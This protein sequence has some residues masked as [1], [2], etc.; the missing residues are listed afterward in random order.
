[1]RNQKTNRQKGFTVIELMVV[2]VIM[3][4]LTSAGIV[5]WNQQ[6]PRRTLAIA[7][8]ETITNLRKVQAY[9][10]SSRNL[11]T[12]E[13]PKYYLT[14]FEGGASSYTV[15]AIA[16]TSFSYYDVE[17]INLPSGVT[18]GDITLRD[19]SGVETD[20]KC[21]FVISGV[22]FGKTY[23]Y[24]S[25]ICDSSISAVA[26]NF[27]ELAPWAN[28]SMDL[29]LS[30]SQDG[31]SKV[32]KVHGLS[33]KVEQ[34]EPGPNFL[35]GPAIDNPGDGDGNGDGSG[36]GQY[37]GGGRDGTGDVTGGGDET[38]DPPLP[39]ECT[40]GGFYR[41]LVETVRTLLASSYKC[42]TNVSR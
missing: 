37:G 14:R 16:S 25:S 4:L 40:E 7:Q 19:S 18:A 41:I 38:V 39:P 17:T 6:K 21:A 13:A 11:P 34:A 1:M 27:P 8:N 24:G 32:L 12:G 33:G 5:I 29:T 15:H 30:H 20:Y 9:A 26:Q 3:V 10:V 36:G 22:V 35:G 31:S 42:Y 23:L 2:F 28:Y